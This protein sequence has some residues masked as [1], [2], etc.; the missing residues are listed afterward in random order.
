MLN[1]TATRSPGASW[2][3]SEPTAS[4][5]PIGSWP[6]M[7][8]GP[9]KAPSTSYRCRSEPQ[10]PLD[11]TRTIASVGC[12]IVGSGTSSTRTSCVPCQVNAFIVLLALLTAL[13]LGHLTLGLL[14]HARAILVRLLVG[15]APPSTLR[16]RV[17]E[18]RA[19][20]GDGLLVVA[21]PRLARAAVGCR[22]P[23]AAPARVARC[24][25]AAPPAGR[26]RL[27]LA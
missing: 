9:M 21:G 3:T 26:S 18:L 2:W 27:A 15:P 6:R 24:V 17:V 16:R 22:A 1:G 12:S 20:L 14:D 10:M 11:V 23:G 25:G 13:A 5:M 8:P 4:T 7:S 19:N